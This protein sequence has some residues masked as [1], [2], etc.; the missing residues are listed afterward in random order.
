M[1]TLKSQFLL[2]PDIIFL[3]H[4]SFGATPRPVFTAYQQWQRRL[5]NQPV[6]FL[7]QELGDHLA[8]ARQALG[9][10]INAPATDLVYVPNATFAVNIVARSLQLGPGDELLTTDHEYGAC[11]NTWEFMSRQRGFTI[12]RQPLPL[13]TTSQATLA[14]QLW[15][16]VTPRTRAI[17]LSHITSATALTLPVADICARARAAGIL[18]IVDGAHTV[19]QIPLNMAT[20]GADFYTSNNHK[21]LMAPKGSAFL[22]ARPEVQHL[23]QPLVVG[24]GWGENR[25]LTYGSDFLDYQQWLGTNDLSAYLAT[26]DAITF[27][28]NH[29]WPLVR[30]VCH[31]MAIATLHRLSAITGLPPVYPPTAELCNQLFVAPL[32]PVDV[33]AFKNALY[34]QYRIEVPVLNWQHH[35]FIRV[36][37]QGYNTPAD[38][39]AL[40]QAVTELL[41]T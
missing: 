12:V 14:D 27:Q 36:S 39:D 33:V 25:T 34:T 6:H 3:N 18:T 10:L 21:W 7:T 17:F 20:I 9:N 15:A 30:E 11:L 2:D 31:Q 4:G 13:P 38:L 28:H 35:T 37:V 40:V 19:G 32:P 23:L 24:W 5:E 22:Y 8:T 26:P 29:N 1:A 16:G 41:A